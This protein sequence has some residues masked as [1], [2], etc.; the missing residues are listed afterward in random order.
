MYVCM[1]SPV[2]LQDIARRSV[3]YCTLPN[4]DTGKVEVVVDSSF[5]GLTPLNTP[6][7]E[8]IAEYATSLQWFPLL[9]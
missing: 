4:E 7:G 6:D 2:F 8:I 9:I 1:V 3:K 5:D